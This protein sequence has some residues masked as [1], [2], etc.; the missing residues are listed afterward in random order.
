M[1]RV[2]PKDMF[3]ETPHDIIMDNRVLCCTTFKLK[4]TTFE[5]TVT[6]DIVAM[7]QAQFN[8]P[9]YPSVTGWAS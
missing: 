6:G 9:E 8:A 1:I 2:L 5:P 3:L 4:M 7:I